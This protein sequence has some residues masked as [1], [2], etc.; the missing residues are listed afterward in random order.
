MS[1]DN[2]DMGIP[3]PLNSMTNK[4]TPVKT[5]PFHNLVCIPVIV[6]DPP[7]VNVT[8]NNVIIAQQFKN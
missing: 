8:N 5:L 1:G 7:T 2:G 6:A 3:L 4:Q